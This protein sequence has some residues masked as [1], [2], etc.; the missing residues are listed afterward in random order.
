MGTNE[1]IKMMQAIIKDILEVNY[2]DAKYRS[3]KIR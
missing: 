3:I 1:T 2:H